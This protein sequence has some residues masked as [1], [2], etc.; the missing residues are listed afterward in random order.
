MGFGWTAHARTN[1][2]ARRPAVTRE[3]AATYHVV[4]ARQVAPGVA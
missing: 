4:Y 1:A 2:R 3:P